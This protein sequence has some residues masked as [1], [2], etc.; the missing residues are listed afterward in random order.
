M[1]RFNIGDNVQSVS[2]RENG[3]I[4]AHLQSSVSDMM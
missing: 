1:A 2:T 3:V 4:V